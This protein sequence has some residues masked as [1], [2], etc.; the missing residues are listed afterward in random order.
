MTEPLGGLCA[1]GQH[2]ECGLDGER[3]PFDHA[4]HRRDCHCPCHARR[5]EDE[6]E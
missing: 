5:R 4:P 3:G 2:L 6:E 1:E